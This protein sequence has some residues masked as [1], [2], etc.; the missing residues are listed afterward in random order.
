MMVRFARQL[1]LALTLVVS[2]CSGA[3]AEHSVQAKAEKTRPTIVHVT[4]GCDA[5]AALLAHMKA[6]GVKLE[7]KKA[8]RAKYPLF[9]TVDYSDGLYDHGERIYAKKVAVPK[10]VKVI[11]CASGT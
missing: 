2:L 4:E 9:P 6:A 10:S 8:E 5:C 3:S 7:A 11:R 1:G